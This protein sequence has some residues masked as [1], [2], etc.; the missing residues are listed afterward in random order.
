MKNIIFTILTLIPL[1]SICQSIDTIKVNSDQIKKIYIGLTFSPAYCYR[2]LKTDDALGQ[3]VIDSRDTREIPKFGFTTGVG[4]IYILNKRFNFETGLLFSDKGE[5]TKKTDL[6]WSQPDPILPIKSTFIYSYQYLDIPLKVNY[7]IINKKL[8]FFISAGLSA[9]I[10]LTYKQTSIQEFSDGRT[11]KHTSGSIYNN[12]SKV[13][14]AL[15]AGFGID[16]DLNNKIRFRLESIYRRS[17]NSII[18]APVKSYL[19]S[20]GLNAGIYYKLSN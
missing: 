11:E 2:T 7:Y 18:D 1:T 4:L 3:L 17:I 19:Y 10:F 16:Y 13:N 9:N 6:I 5:K 8:N 12:F 15:L 20:A 14:F